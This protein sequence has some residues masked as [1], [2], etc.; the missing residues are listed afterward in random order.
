MKNKRTVPIRISSSSNDYLHSCGLS[1]ISQRKAI[2]SSGR[3]QPDVEGMKQVILLL[4]DSHLDNR[5]LRNY[6]RQSVHTFTDMNDQWLRNFRKKTLKFVL[7][8]KL[9]FGHKDLP[10]LKNS[11]INAANENIILDS[12]MKETNYRNHL[13]QVLQD[14]GEGWNVL[15]LLTMVKDKAST[16]N[17]RIWF[18]SNSKPRGVCW[19]TSDMRKRLIRHGHVLFIDAQKRQYNKHGWVYIGPCVRGHNNRTG[20]VIECLCIEESLDAYTWVLESLFMMEDSMKKEDIKLIFGDDFI[21][22]RLLV[23]L[24]IEKTCILRCDVFHCLNLTWPKHFGVTTWARIGGGMSEMLYAKTID[25]WNSSFQ[26]VKKI[27]TELGLRRQL[28][29]IEN[30]IYGNPNRYSNHFLKSIEGNCFHM[31][32]TPAEQNHASNVAHMGK[33]ATWEI[34]EHVANLLQRDRDISQSHSTEDIEW[35]QGSSTFVSLFDDPS[36]NQDD[37]KARNWMSKF[38]YKE[39]WLKVVSKS[40]SLTVSVLENGTKMVHRIG[41][42]P[43]SGIIMKHGVRCSC[44]Y[45]I[46]LMCQCVHEYIVDGRLE[47]DKYSK[48]HWMSKDKFIVDTQSSLFVNSS[49]A[50]ISPEENNQFD[51]HSSIDKTEYIDGTNDMKY[52]FNENLS[53]H[54]NISLELSYNSIVD[55]GKEIARC[56]QND[57]NAMK[58]VSCAMNQM[59]DTLR[60]KK[61]AN[62]SD[63]NYR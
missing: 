10:Y 13:R 41:H 56:V 58:A 6:L 36:L 17:Y 15:K 32:S 51:C 57:T 59:I 8:P 5:A 12:E 25:E 33:G 42:P 54:N 49:S 24:Q 1:T 35:Y 23:N 16:F 63:F 11:R 60:N 37:K 55:L 4:R 22:D 30:H 27:L 21:T 31:G 44:F 40:N 38:A 18:D 28:D 48:Q 50:S 29:Y 39:I 61:G 47:L 3:S 43:E 14:S 62:R 53:T 45:R 7:D 20:T 9:E 19:I 34:A 46:G 26:Y 52:S 2:Q